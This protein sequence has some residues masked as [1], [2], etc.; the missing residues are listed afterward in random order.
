MQ[1]T[2]S[3]ES[4]LSTSA[5]PVV[6]TKQ[7]E[8]LPPG[9]HYVDD[10]QPG[11][12][13]RL[14]AGHFA[15]FDS[16]G[17][18][19]RDAAEVARINALVIPPAY[20]QVWICADPRGHLQ[21]TG[22]DARGRKQYRYHPR[23]RETRDA[24][25]YERMLAFSAALPRIRARVARDLKLSGLQRDKVLATVVRLL[26]TTLIRIGNV[27]YAKENRSY[28]LT[29]LR[30]RHV[31]VAAGQIHFHFRGKSGVEHDVTV[32]DARVARIVKRCMDIPG[33]D[34]FQYLDDEGGRHTVS[35]ADINEYLHAVAGADFTAKDY[36]TWAG[37]VHALDALSKIRWETVTEARRLL[38]ETVKAVA[39]RLGNTPAVC[40]R[41]YV[42]PAVLEA[43]EAGELMPAI[44]VVSMSAPTGASGSGQTGA[45]P[46]SARKL[47]KALKQAAGAASPA[48]AS[49]RLRKQG[50][51]AAEV[52][53]ANFLATR[54]AVEASADAGAPVARKKSTPKAP[55]VTAGN[56][57][58]PGKRANRPA[59]SNAAR[60]SRAGSASSPRGKSV[61]IVAG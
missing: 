36:R 23:W 15:Y 48:A 40:K 52:A 38:V 49:A 53:L 5:A 27:D 59:A 14:A 21:A 18:R 11:I 3:L 6:V 19:I 17:R 16:Q 30:N 4:D 39:R 50:L 13:R 45:L 34:L 29:T 9:L 58:A 37:S 10:R 61:T 8:D 7:P 43:F 54:L 20:Q 56:R 24:T 47:S 25:K 2:P 32:S 55:R 57:T 22:R 12:S 44:E 46:A 28:G 42:H 31:D 35:S 41:C 1:C 60:A 51:K 26:D 33:H